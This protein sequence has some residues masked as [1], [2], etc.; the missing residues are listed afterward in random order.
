MWIQLGV[1]ASLRLGWSM[2][3]FLKRRDPVMHPRMCSEATDFNSAQQ[4]AS[5]IHKDHVATSLCHT[6][7]LWAWYQHGSTIS[8]TALLDRTA[9]F[10]RTANTYDPGMRFSLYTAGH[11]M[12]LFSSFL[13]FLF[14]FFFVLFFVFVLF[15]IIFFGFFF[16]FLLFFFFFFAAPNLRLPFQ[17]SSGL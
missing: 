16:V 5:S 6:Q 7:Q 11:Q 3:S 1:Q 17:A 12:L 10:L 8:T 14:L 9:R 15:V 4:A 13:S 2:F